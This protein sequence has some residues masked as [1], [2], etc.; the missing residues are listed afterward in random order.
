MEMGDG[1]RVQSTDNDKQ[2]TQLKRTFSLN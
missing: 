1:R 2:I